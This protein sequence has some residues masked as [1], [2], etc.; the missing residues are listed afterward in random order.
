VV[1]RTILHGEAR[2]VARVEPNFAGGTSRISIA[3]S[4]D[5]LARAAGACL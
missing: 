4:A 2:R 3:S 5:W 1:I